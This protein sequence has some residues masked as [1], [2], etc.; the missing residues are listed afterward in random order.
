MLEK[1]GYEVIV[2]EFECCGLPMVA[3]GFFDDA[4]A[5]ASRNVD[6]LA[7]LVSSGDVPV[8]TVCPSCQ[9]MLKQE[10][11]EYFPELGKHESIVPH[12]QDAC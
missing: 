7:A 5:A 10:Y 9:L 1:A 2:P 6:T 12:V 11:V 4:R 8:L 3:N